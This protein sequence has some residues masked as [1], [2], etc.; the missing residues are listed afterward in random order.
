MHPKARDTS[1]RKTGCS[2]AAPFCR[3][4]LNVEEIVRSEVRGPG[5]GGLLFRFGLKQIYDVPH[6]IRDQS[7]DHSDGLVRR[8]KD[9]SH[10]AAGPLKM[11]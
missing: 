4:V 7:V 6:I 2:F 11:I 1:A 9:E 8:R 5:D 3:Q 10:I